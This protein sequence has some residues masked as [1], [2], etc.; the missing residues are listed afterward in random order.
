MKAKSQSIRW[1][2]C[3]WRLVTC[4]KLEWP[5][6]ECCPS[7]WR[8]LYT[9]L[10]FWKEKGRRRGK[11]VSIP[12][13]SIVKSTFNRYGKPGAFLPYGRY[14]EAPPPHFPVGKI[15]ALEEGALTDQ[16]PRAGTARA[17]KSPESCW[18]PPPS[19]YCLF[20]FLV[21]ITHYTSLKSK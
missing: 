13:K 20:P 19:P 1:K 18:E 8:N 15:G 9:Q 3:I 17:P 10:K 5:K 16:G 12:K 21:P 6:D 11:D 14:L 7:K 2:S 4:W